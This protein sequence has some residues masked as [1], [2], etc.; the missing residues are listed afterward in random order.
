MRACSR[1]RGAG[2]VLVALTW[3]RLALAWWSE[4][5]EGQQ[6]DACGGRELM[7]NMRRVHS[8][9]GQH[10][11]HSRGGGGADTVLQLTPSMP[12]GRLTT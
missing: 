1:G 5:Q 3:A 7:T 12:V 4:G 10:C 2:G 8:Y 11:S 9:G 6:T